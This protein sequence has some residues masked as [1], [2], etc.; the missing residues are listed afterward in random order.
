MSLKMII[1]QNFRLKLEAL[2]V[3][4]FYP[5]LSNVPLICYFELNGIY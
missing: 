1:N 3:R 5:I 4:V 2:G